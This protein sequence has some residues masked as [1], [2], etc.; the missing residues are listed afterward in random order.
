MALKFKLSNAQQCAMEQA[1]KKGDRFF[2]A[3]LHASPWQSTT[4]ASIKRH[5]GMCYVSDLV[6]HQPDFYYT[7][8]VESES[9]VIHDAAGRNVQDKKHFAQKQQLCTFAG[10]FARFPLSSVTMTSM[11]YANSN[12]LIGQ[13][14]S[15]SARFWTLNTDNFLPHYKWQVEVGW[16]QD[17]IIVHMYSIY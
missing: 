11:T 3:D 13:N 17:Y 5:S 12:E 15:R 9:W 2:L 8:H 6:G 14:A 16:G 7:V 4:S 10:G 1:S